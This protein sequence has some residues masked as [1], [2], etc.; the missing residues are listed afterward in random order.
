MTIGKSK[1]SYAEFYITNVCNL[2]C[3][4]CNR[5]NNYAFKNHHDIDEF[6]PLYRQW[7]NILEIKKISILGGEPLLNPDWHRW[8]YMIRELWPNCILDIITNGTMLNKIKNLYHVLTET[9]TNLE[10]N[11]HNY[12]EYANLAK[13]L[14]DFFPGPYTIEQ[15]DFQSSFRMLIS[16]HNVNL[17]VEKANSQHFVAIHN[18]DRGVI[19]P[20]NNDIELAH[21]NC[22]MKNCH[23]FAYGKLY[24]CGLEFLLKDFCEQFD[25]IYDPNDQ[26]LI[27]S[28]NGITVENWLENP[29][30]AK[31]HLKNPIQHCK[32]CPKDI[33]Y[34]NIRPSLGNT[35][36]IVS[37]PA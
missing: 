20:Y 13:R 4:N 16:D 8:A 3:D 22:D 37:T 26:D 5:F 10:I 15:V 33:E 29:D 18:T 28:D 27:E 36:I 1:L 6:Q 9:Q 11:L 12:D 35:E 19:L 17:S 25:A 34:K 23:H 21:Q 14:D 7:A 31:Q 24:K 32:L 30:S 2:T